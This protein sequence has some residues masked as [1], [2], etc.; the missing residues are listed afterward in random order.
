M[1]IFAACDGRY[2]RRFGGLFVLSAADL[3]YRVRVTVVPP[4]DQGGMGQVLARHLDGRFELDELPQDTA[5]RSPA[6]YSCLRI[7]CLLD[8]LA[9]QPEGAWVVVCDVDSIWKSALPPLREDAHVMIRR[10][11]PEDVDSKWVRGVREGRAWALQGCTTTAGI[12]GVRNTPE[13]RRFAR[14]AAYHVEDLRAT[15]YGHKQLVDQVALTRAA[16]AGFGVPVHTLDAAPHLWHAFYSRAGDRW[17]EAWYSDPVVA[18][19]KQRLD[20]LMETA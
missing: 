17:S 19:W 3:G 4:P 5:L 9:S 18:P 14:R 8:V 11:G 2:W 13:G 1:L 20:V 12:F 6:W 10:N 16:P 15:G 7:M